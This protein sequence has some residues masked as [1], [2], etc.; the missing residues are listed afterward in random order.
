MTIGRLPSLVGVALL[1]LV[2]NVAVSI[3]Y[4]VV[5]GHL[6]DPGHEEQYYHD[7]INVAAPYCSIV[8]GIP[9][10]FWAGWWVGGRWEV[11]FAVKAAL[12]IWLS[13]ALIDL[14]VLLAAGLTTRIAALFVVSILTKLA[15]VYVGALVAR[16]RA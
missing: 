2:V 11:E 8:A 1:V 3:L 7:H 16:R 6:I 5:Y 9:L 15:A 12:T 10:M 14:A 4:M 13:Y